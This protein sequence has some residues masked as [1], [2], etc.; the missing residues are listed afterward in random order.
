MDCFGV[1]VAIFFCPTLSLFVRCG[2][3][4]VLCDGAAMRG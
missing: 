2:G 1:G 3:V 4:G